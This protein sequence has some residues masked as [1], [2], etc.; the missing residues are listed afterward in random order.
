MTSPARFISFFLLLFL[1]FIHQVSAQSLDGFTDKNALSQLRLEQELIPKFSSETYRTHLFNLT[2]KP[3]V[4]GTAESREVI[5]YMTKAMSDAGLDVKEYDYDVWLPVQG[6][7]RVSIVQPIRMPLN[8]Q[9]FIFDDD[10]YTAHAML[11]KGWNAYSGSGDVTAEVVYANYGR[12][13]DFQQLA[14][15]GV[16][17]S[18]K[19]VIARYGGNF[20]GYKAKFAE[21]AGAVGLIIYTDP[22]DGGYMSG[23]VYPDGPYSNESTIQRGSLLTMDYF[24]DPLTPFEPALPL[25]GDRQIERLPIDEVP[26]HSIPVTPL[27]YGSAIEILSRMEGAYIGHRSWQGGLPFTYRL[28]G[29]PDLKVNLVVDQPHRSQRITNVIG[30]IEGSEYPDEWII[31]GSHHDAWGFGATDP[32]S[33][34]ALLLTLADVLGDAAQN[35][36]RP[37]R[38]IMV[39]HW[40]AE[41][42]LLIGSTEWVEEL[43]EELGAQAIMYINADMAVTGPN[44]RSASSPSLK[45]PIIEASK[46]IPHPDYD[47]KS[48]FDTWLRNPSDAEPPIGN[49]GGGSDHVGFYMHLGIPS[50]GV[51]ISGTVPIY[52]S[53]YDTFWFYEHHLDSGFVYGPTLSSMYAVLALRFANADILPY[54]VP[55]YSIDLKKHLSSI[56]DLFTKANR[57]FSSHEIKTHVD[58]LHIKLTELD[59]ALKKAPSLSS[60]KKEQINNLLIR[61]ERAFLHETG[62]DF[63]EWLKSLYAAPDPYSGYAS[64][65][66]PAYHYAFHETYSEA[67][68]SR[69]HHIHIQAIKRLM[70]TADEILQII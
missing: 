2:Q 40:D 45:K 29:G 9:E 22:N 46:A 30:T 5:N 14:K 7:S 47:D 20:R 25:D 23:P 24:G 16:D 18:G 50:A 51:S 19:I 42:F 8:D 58:E 1:I 66:L 27:P 15:W 63:S 17:V 60:E 3:H 44:F 11:K 64:W 43:R 38:S 65:M 10:P 28:T 32:N 54:Y 36:Q 69:L 67:D 4:A 13:Q 49:L 57:T 6:E 26:F 61:L 56:E 59:E 68:I 21:E 33:G 41:E 37:K 31:L 53:N 35:G 62:L 34:T 12:K 70:E 52:H 48:L 39:G 55:Q